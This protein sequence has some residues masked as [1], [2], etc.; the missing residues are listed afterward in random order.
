ML[1]PATLCGDKMQT[2]QEILGQIMEE[3]GLEI[4]NE[5]EGQEVDHRGEDPRWE[6]VK[7]CG[8]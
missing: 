4:P 7:D 5:D 6:R 2:I 3:L 8:D 1:G